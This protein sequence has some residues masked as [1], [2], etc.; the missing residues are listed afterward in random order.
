[1]IWLHSTNFSRTSASTS[2][3]IMRDI[4]SH[5][6]NACT[7]KSIL[8]FPSCEPSLKPSELVL[9]PSMPSAIPSSD[10]SSKPSAMLSAA[11]K[12]EPHVAP[13]L[14]QSSISHLM[15]SH[16]WF[17]H[18][19]INHSFHVS[20]TPSSSP[21]FMPCAIQSQHPSS[22]KK[23]IKVYVSYISFVHAWSFHFEKVKEED[24]HWVVNT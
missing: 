2:A 18:H 22:I 23:L 17:Y 20:K 15:P 19:W 12:N 16:E 10:T 5:P 11:P 14:K 9:F 8:L 6:L 3:V 21:T 13:S 24:I 4:G 7:Q 1:M